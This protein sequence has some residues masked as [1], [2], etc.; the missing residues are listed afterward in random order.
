MTEFDLIFPRLIFLSII[1]LVTVSTLNVLIYDAL[2]K[3]G[4][5]NMEESRYIPGPPDMKLSCL[6]P[7]K[8][9]SFTLIGNES[10]KD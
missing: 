10:L 1:P 4:K 3:S 9:L 5:N 8:K 6:K 2:V 7:K